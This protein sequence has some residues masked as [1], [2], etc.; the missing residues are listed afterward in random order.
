MFADVRPGFF[1]RLG[2][3]GE[4]VGSAFECTWLNATGSQ[5]DARLGDQ[6]EYCMDADAIVCGD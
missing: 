1:S 3:Q 2:H 4:V 6:N 5:T